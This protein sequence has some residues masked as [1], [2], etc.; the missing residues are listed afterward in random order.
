MAEVG[1]SLQSWP[2]L[3]GRFCPQSQSN[4]C[5]FSSISTRIYLV[6]K[7]W[8]RFNGEDSAK[9]RRRSE[10]NANRHAQ[11]RRQ[12]QTVDCFEFSQRR[13]CGSK[14]DWSTISSA[15]PVNFVAEPTWLQLLLDCS[16][17]SWVRQGQRMEQRQ[18]CGYI[19]QA[20]K[21]QRAHREFLLWI[22]L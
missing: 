2:P 4:R 18:N 22:A 13:D 6:D 9:W 10:S 3:F 19:H 7:P 1:L 15:L 21:N 11:L 8:L 14:S 5:N 12:I 17:Q 16:D 20:A